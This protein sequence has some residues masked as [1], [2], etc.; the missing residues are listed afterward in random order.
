ML[1]FGSEILHFSCDIEKMRQDSDYF[2]I[3]PHLLSNS[4][5]TGVYT[6]MNTGRETGRHFFRRLPA[7]KRAGTKETS[8]SQQH[9]LGTKTL[10]LEALNG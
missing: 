3:K 2:K 6:F 7:H 5:Q 9:M 10:Y 1:L 4:L 8:A